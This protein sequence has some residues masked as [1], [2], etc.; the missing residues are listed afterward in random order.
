[1]I[2][3]TAQVV[4]E[5][6]QSYLSLPFLGLP[7]ERGIRK[8]IFSLRSLRLVLNRVLFLTQCL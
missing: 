7:L 3:F 4:T 2:L 8:F 5:R 1:M 6:G